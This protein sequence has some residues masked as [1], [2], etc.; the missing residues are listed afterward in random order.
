MGLPRRGLGID[1]NVNPEGHTA[2]SIQEAM[3]ILGAE[4]GNLHDSR[5]Y[6]LGNVDVQP[7][8]FATMYSGS[9]PPVPPS[10]PSGSTYDTLDTPLYASAPARVFEISFATVPSTTPVFQIWFPGSTAGIQ[11]P[12]V[13]RV[14]TRTYRFCV[15]A[16][17]EA[18]ITVG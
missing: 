9:L 12:V 10:V 5:A 13:E 7:D 4:F 17:T 2:A 14:S 1:I 3:T 15:P 6:D 16:A 18:K 8:T 11:V